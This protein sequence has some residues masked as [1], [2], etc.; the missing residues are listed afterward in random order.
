MRNQ[1]REYLTAKL[2]SGVTFFKYGGK[3]YK[4]INPTPSQML[5]GDEIARESVE[6]N[7]FKQLLSEEEAKEYLNNKGIWTYEDEKLFEESEKTIE[8]MKMELCEKATLFKKREADSIRSKIQGIRRAISEAMPR[9][10]MITQMTIEHHYR[11]IK[12]QFLAAVCTY[13]LSGK[14]QYDE[15]SYFTEQGV[16][17]EQAYEARQRDT[18]GQT[19]LRDVARNEPWKGYWQISKQNVF[20]GTME[21]IFGPTND[22]AIII[23]SSHLNPN[24]R[25]IV[26]ISKMYDN[27]YQHPE[28][29]R[30]DIIEDDD[31]FDGW[32]L[33]ENKKQEREK[34][35]KSIDNMAD[36]KGDELFIMASNLQEAKEIVQVNNKGEQLKMAK[37]I[38][39]ITSQ[40]E[41]KE[42]DM[43]DT[44]ME[45]RRQAIAESVDRRRK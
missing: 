17:M 4:I 40:G 19:E 21:S 22:E 32:M 3:R 1:E 26:R 2:L 29:P 23:P 15:S 37:R 13:D 6:N 12:D 10:Y 7:R 25:N 5:L 35:K 18:F 34:K 24:Q 8:E 36:K 41:V 42:A 39:Q 44:K 28:C 45:L 30:D 38:N 9:K 43:F 33:A 16:I 31:C 14:R 27:V 11:M 20:G